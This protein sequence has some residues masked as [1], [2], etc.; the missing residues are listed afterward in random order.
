MAEYLKDKVKRKVLSIGG[1]EKVSVTI[2]DEPWDWNDS[3]NKPRKISSPPENISLQENSA[4][5]LF[6]G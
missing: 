6:F 2:L 3:K 1:I 4:T 5:S